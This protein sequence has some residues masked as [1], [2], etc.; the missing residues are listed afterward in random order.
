MRWGV[1]DGTRNPASGGKVHD[2][3]VITASMCSLLD[4]MDWHVPLPGF[5]IP[6]RDP[7]EDMDGRF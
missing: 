2:D 3:D 5:I 1:P 7:L 6:G 4:R